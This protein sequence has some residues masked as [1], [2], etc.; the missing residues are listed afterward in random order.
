[1]PHRS[2][3]EWSECEKEKWMECEYPHSAPH[4]GWTHHH[5]THDVDPYNS[6][7]LSVDVDV[8]VISDIDVVV[9]STWSV[10]TA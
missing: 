9:P 6:I 10:S 1:M 7:S 8:V 3:E 2:P 5:W 4:K